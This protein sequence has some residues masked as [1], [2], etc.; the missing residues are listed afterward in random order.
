M[1]RKKHWKDQLQN[2]LNG[3]GIKY[4]L[5]AISICLHAL[6]VFDVYY[7]ISKEESQKVIFKSNIFNVIQ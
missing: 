4:A 1:P 5:G 2:V 6:H 7:F 3:C